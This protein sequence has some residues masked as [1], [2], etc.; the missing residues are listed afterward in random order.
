M[1][2]TIKFVVHKKNIIDNMTSFMLYVRKGLGHFG[3]FLILAI[4]S[5]LTFALFF[6]GKIYFVG[7]AVNFSLGFLFAGFTEYLHW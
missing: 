3:A 2:Y 1:E 5:T 4:F 7:V 6:R